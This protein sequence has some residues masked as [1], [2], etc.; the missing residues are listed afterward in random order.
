MLFVHEVHAV[1]GDSEDE[2]E[3]HIRDGWMPALAKSGDARLLWYLDHAHGSGKSYR[4]VTVT[5]V[6]DAGAWAALCDRLDGGDLTT[7]QRE[8]DNLRHDS[9]AKVLVPLP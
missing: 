8:L 2:F 3:S 4:V 9:E 7:W 1:R 5:G 6:R